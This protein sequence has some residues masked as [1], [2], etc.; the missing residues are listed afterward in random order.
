MSEAMSEETLIDTASFNI[1]IDTRTQLITDYNSITT[2]YNRIAEKLLNNRNG[3]GADVLKHD[4]EKI[5][6]DI[7][8]ICDILN[9][10][11][12]TLE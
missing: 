12:D 5:R 2:E 9:T 11:C 3:R 4:A 10:M 1:V 8:G 7:G 6:T